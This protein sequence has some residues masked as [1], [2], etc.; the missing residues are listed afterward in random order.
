MAARQ[1]VVVAG[2]VEAEKVVWGAGERVYKAA[3]VERS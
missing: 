2:G 3:G 1:M